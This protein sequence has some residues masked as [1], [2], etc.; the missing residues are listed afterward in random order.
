M[1]YAK[2][3]NG[4]IV[5]YNRSLPFSTE[6]TSFGLNT[7]L[8]VML[9][10]GYLP[11]VGEQPALLEN[12]FVDGISYNVESDKVVKV[13]S[14]KTLTAE[15][16]LKASVPNSITPRQARLKLLETDLLDNLEVVIATN[17][18]WQI[19]WEYATEVKRDSPI[20]DAVAVQAGLTELQIDTM[21]IEASKL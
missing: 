17:R 6:T 20:I 5:E 7:P 15:E 1:I 16:V 4:E 2:V 14:V 9:A 19:E 21:F 10:N 12:Q 11:V 3:I 13:Y 18:A 8:E